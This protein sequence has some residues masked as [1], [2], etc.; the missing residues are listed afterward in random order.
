LTKKKKIIDSKNKTLNFNFKQKNRH[1][2]IFAQKDGI[3][4]RE[5]QNFK[6]EWILRDKFINRIG[7]AGDNLRFIDFFNG[8][9]DL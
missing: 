2:N 9:R 4:T 8:K 3:K 5:G 1:Q 7:Q 6:P